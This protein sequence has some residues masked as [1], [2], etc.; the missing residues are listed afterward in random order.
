MLQELSVMKKL[1]HYIV[2]YNLGPVALAAAKLLDAERYR[3][4]AATA[5][6]KSLV[7]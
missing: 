6:W 1:N 2:G 7:T 3:C 5:R 4:T